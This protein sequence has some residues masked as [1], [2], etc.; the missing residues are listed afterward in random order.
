MYHFKN[1]INNHHNWYLID[2]KKKILGRLATVIAHY[3][4]G[5]HKITYSPHIDG[6]DYITVINAEKIQVTGNKKKN[7]M[8]Y[9][10]SGYSGGIKKI[11]LNELINHYPDRVIKNAVKGML[12]KNKIG[13]LILNRLKI[14]SGIKHKH[15]A[16]KHYILNI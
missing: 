5:K 6:G 11:S 13:Y 2:A 7:K 15:I 8:Y 10:H 4:M 12:P 16:Q 1:N 3:L 14:Y 9:K